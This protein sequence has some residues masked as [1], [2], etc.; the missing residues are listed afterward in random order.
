MNGFE[1]FLRGRGVEIAAL[2]LLVAPFAISGASKAVDFAGAIDEVRGLSGLEP[3]W[4]F[5]ALVVLAQLL[6][7][8]AVVFGRRAVIPGAAALAGFTC[9]AT[10]LAHAWW[11]KDGIDR[12]RDFNV[13]WEHVSIVGG[14]ALAAI[15][16]A[17]RET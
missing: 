17:R 13:F 14:L 2:T 12:V 3:A 4:I 16:A 1:T 8:L 5:A 9:V 7:A 6:G 15:L 10:L 11:T